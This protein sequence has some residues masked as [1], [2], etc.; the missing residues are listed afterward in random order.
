MTVHT[1]APPL[2]V[3]LTVDDLRELVADVIAASIADASREPALLTQE[4]LAHKLGV[5]VGTVRTLRG[6]GLPTIT[7]GESP[8][9]EL[10]AVLEWLRNA[11]TGSNSP[12][13]R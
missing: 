1:K 11:R 12:E 10:A 3:T 6:R 4:Q 7:V 9:F 8:R 5:S 13:E 2:V